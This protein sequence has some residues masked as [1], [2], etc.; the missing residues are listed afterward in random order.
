MAHISEKLGNWL[1]ARLF[2]ERKPII[3]SLSS[4]SRVAFGHVD[5][6]LRRFCSLQVSRPPEIP[7]LHSTRSAWVASPVKGESSCTFNFSHI[8]RVGCHWIRWGHV[9]LPHSV[10]MA[11]E[12][13]CSMGYWQG[14]G[15]LPTPKTEGRNQPRAHQGAGTG[16]RGRGY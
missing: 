9:P 10:T 12:V 15:H 5:F 3:R 4:A 8:P 2:Q 16:S 13:G 6:S 11:R 14:L 1:Q 7:G